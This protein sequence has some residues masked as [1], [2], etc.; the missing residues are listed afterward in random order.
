VSADF[1]WSESVGDFYE[2]VHQ[3]SEN[4]IRGLA[5]DARGSNAAEYRFGNRGA[6]WELTVR[7]ARSQDGGEGET[8]QTELRLAT[9]RISKSIFLHP[10]FADVP[11]DQLEAL[12]ESEIDNE[13]SPALTHPQAIELYLALLRGVD[14]YTV[15]EPVLIVTD[16][17]STKFNF[18]NFREYYEN[19][20][21]VHP[22]DF[23][24]ALYQTDL[25]FA[26]PDSDPPHGYVAGWLKNPP[27]YQRTGNLKAM[28]SQEWEYGHWDVILYDI[29][30]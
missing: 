23:L 20:D 2:E 9:N 21:R 29:A 24:E 12:R 10:A 11:Q 13:Q 8:P 15:N 7:W 19:V 14:H 30:P 16:I 25:R 27:E 4:H 26:L 5:A 28:I 6:L 3:G 22:T 1:G 18:T 17:A